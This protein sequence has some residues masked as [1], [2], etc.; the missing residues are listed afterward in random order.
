MTKP[1]AAAIA[2]IALFLLPALHAPPAVAQPAPGTYALVTER[3]SARFLVK[4]PVGQLRAQM[5]FR[6]GALVFGPDG[7]LRD[8]RAVLR[9]GSVRARRAALDAMLKGRS[10][11]DVD[12]HPLIRFEGTGGGLD[13]DTLVIE[14][15]LTI[16]G[17]TRQVRFAGPLRV[18]GPRRIAMTLETEIDRT[19]FGVT[20]G[21]PL[22]SRFATVRLRLVA[23][24]RR[25]R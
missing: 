22:Y 15:A 2:L 10:G 19:A 6:D 12:R 17:V 7:S 9:A 25:G 16:K 20:A 24:R 1:L 3:A 13:G 14:G 18:R 21:R 8:V 5:T 23:V 11:L 4:S